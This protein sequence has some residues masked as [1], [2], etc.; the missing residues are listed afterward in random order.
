M[1]KVGDKFIT[2]VSGLC[3]TAES[4]ICEITSVFNDN[5]YFRAN[6]GEFRYYQWLDEHFDIIPDTYTATKV[7]KIEELEQRIETL[8]RLLN[9]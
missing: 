9:A 8:E 1:I 4:E 7:N 6:D 2:K 5:F 3:W